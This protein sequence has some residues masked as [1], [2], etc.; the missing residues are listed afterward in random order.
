MADWKKN[1]E[2]SYNRKKQGKTW[3]ITEGE[4]TFR[5]LP[6]KDAILHYKDNRDWNEACTAF[7]PML[8]FMA[9]RD[10]GADKKFIRSGKDT[11]GTGKCWL[12]D[13]VIG[14]LLASNSRSDRAI[15][16]RM[17]P[18][19]QFVVQVA[20]L[21]RVSKS[22]SGPY[23]WYVPKTLQAHIISL[24]LSTRRCYDHPLKGYNLTIT[25][26]GTGQRDTRYGS[27]ETD[28]TSSKVDF[29]ILKSV[30][31]WT[32]VTP[33]YNEDD[34]K[35]AWGDDVPEIEGEPAPRRNIKRKRKR[36]PEPEPDEDDFGDDTDDGT[37]DLSEE[38]DTTEDDD[39]LE[40]FEEDESEPPPKKPVKKKAS[41]KSAKKASKRKSEP[42]EEDD[43]ADADFG[44]DDLPF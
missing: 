38:E 34:Q 42:E 12:T 15:A 2:K 11:D 22:W 4:N 18:Q 8:E 16:E 17:Q 24:I 23:F 27:I 28:E 30:R 1:L 43:D 19:E 25:R 35:A 21:D 40:G 5:L 10:V 37:D 31:P 39:D 14:P 13:K 3:K 26:T 36:K 32:D 9:H 41:K 6:P 33:L 7:A 20:V 44:D 29:G